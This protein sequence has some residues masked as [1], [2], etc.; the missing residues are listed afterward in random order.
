LTGGEPLVKKGI[1]N[2]VSMLSS[3]DKLEIL[4]MTTNATLLAPIEND[5][6]V[7][8]CLALIY[9]LIHLMLKNSEN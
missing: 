8:G 3:I 5:L 2:L 6:K 4:S 7:R 9:L 1:I